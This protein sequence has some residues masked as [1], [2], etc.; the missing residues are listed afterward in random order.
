MILAGELGHGTEAALRKRAR[1]GH[2]F[3]VIHRLIQTPDYLLGRYAQDA[4]QMAEG[5]QRKVLE[6]VCL[7]LDSDTRSRIQLVPRFTSEFALHYRQIIHAGGEGLMVKSIAQSHDTRFRPGTR[8]PH[9]IKVKKMLTVD[10]VITEVVQSHAKTFKNRQ[11]AGAIVC[12]MYVGG[13]LKP[14]THVGT[15]DHNLRLLFGGEPSQYIGRVVEIAAFDQFQSGALRHPS[16]IRLREDKYP[17]DCVFQK[18]EDG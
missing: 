18:E 15:M 12:G 7:M 6:E 2:D 11:M 3:I 5:V 8:S 4:S 16:L 10:M 13:V 17:Q 14:L 9:W 1:L